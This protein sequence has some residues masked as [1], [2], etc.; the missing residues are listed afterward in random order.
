MTQAE[1][2]YHPEFVKVVKAIGGHQEKLYSPRG[3]SLGMNQGTL[4]GKGS[5]QLTSFLR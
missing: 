4:K 5:I 3:N 1:G 2:R